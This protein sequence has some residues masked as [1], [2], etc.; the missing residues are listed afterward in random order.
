MSRLDAL[1][2]MICIPVG[3]VNVQ[4][5][6]ASR[7]SYTVSLEGNS[8]LRTF[9]VKGTNI[10]SGSNM[11]LKFREEVIRSL[12]RNAGWCQDDG[13]CFLVGEMILFGR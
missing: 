10:L 7:V 1:D 5:F 11:L 2:V 8:S 13:F 3:R 6:G 9:N 4:P 12:G